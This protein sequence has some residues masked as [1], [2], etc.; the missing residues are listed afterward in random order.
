MGKLIGRSLTPWGREC[1]AQMILLDKSLED[2]AI[3]TNLSRNYISAII[4]GRIVVPE[5]T[6]DKISSAL[7]ITVQ[8]AVV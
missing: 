3:E 4:N 6:R 7:N 1:K 5:E 8:R 2:L